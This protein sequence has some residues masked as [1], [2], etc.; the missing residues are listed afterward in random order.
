MGLYHYIA[1]APHV[2]WRIAGRQTV[3]VAQIVVTD[4]LESGYGVI[5]VRSALGE[6]GA[7]LGTLPAARISASSLTRRRYQEL[8]VRRS[9][10]ARRPAT[11]F[12][13]I[14]PEPI[15]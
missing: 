4:F 7:R 1:K 9:R 15:P 2:F 11:F 8:S 6:A 12:P 10:F 3:C 13:R 14:P 5:A